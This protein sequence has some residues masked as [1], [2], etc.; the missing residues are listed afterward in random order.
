MP[1]VTTSYRRFSGLFGIGSL[2]IFIFDTRYSSPN[3]HKFCGKLMKI[4]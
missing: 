3:F 1:A 2:E 4:I